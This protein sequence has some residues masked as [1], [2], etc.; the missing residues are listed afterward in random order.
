MKDNSLLP[1]MQQ[2][3]CQ[4]IVLCAEVTQL[5]LISNYSCNTVTTFIQK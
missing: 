3:Y 5:P 4:D 1:F 2:Y